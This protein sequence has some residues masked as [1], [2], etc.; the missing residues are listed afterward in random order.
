MSNDLLIPFLICIGCLGLV[1]FVH[2][3]TRSK[4]PPKTF[5]MPTVK[6][7]THETT[8]QFENLFDVSSPTPADK[9]LATWHKLFETA[10]LDFI[11]LADSFMGSM[12]NK[13][14]PEETKAVDLQKT[15]EAVHVQ[16][17]AAGHPSPEMG[18]EL[19]A[20]LATVAASFHAHLRGDSTLSRKQRLLYEDYR[21]LWFQRLRQFPQ[22]LERIIRLRRA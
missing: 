5:S 16:R 19:S 4:P 11:E 6:L 3:K 7:Q 20:L 14:E 9:S 13:T 2:F 17:A 15:P 1:L 12:G 8:G 18:A 22:N 21:E 10:V